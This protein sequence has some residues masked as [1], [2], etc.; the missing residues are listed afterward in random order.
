M[1]KTYTTPVLAISG[2]TVQETRSVGSS[3]TGESAFTKSIPSGAVGFY[4]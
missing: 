3:P 1:K 2:D 4:L